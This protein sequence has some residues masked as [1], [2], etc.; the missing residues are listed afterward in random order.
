LRADRLRLVA[1]T[2]SGL[3]TR[4]LAATVLLQR[5]VIQRAPSDAGSGPATLAAAVLVET[6]ARGERATRPR[7]GDGDARVAGRSDRPRGGRDSVG[8][9]HVPADARPVL[10][11]PGGRG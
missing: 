7:R 11:G 6:C 1:G 5:R 4:A 2:R 9:V 10:R 3:G 8:D